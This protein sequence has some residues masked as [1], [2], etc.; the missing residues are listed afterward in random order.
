M[1]E[2]V[3]FAARMFARRALARPARQGA[4]ATTVL[5]EAPAG[6][7]GAAVAISPDPSLLFLESCA[8]FHRRRA[9]ARRDGRGAAGT[10][11]AT[12]R[13]SCVSHSQQK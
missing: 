7:R 1:Q 3:R 9:E 4:R 2:T 6:A 5:A 11:L 10:P 12:A 8:L 13:R